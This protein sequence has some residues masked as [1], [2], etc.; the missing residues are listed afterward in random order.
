MDR[1]R[2][3]HIGKWTGTLLCC[4]LRIRFAVQRFRSITAE[5][6]GCR[7]IDCYGEGGKPSACPTLPNS[8]CSTLPA[9]YYILDKNYPRQAAPM[10]KGET[11]TGPGPA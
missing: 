7:E 5:P 1:H 6:T 11:V 2:Q 4:S 8:S 10:P 3:M 9:T